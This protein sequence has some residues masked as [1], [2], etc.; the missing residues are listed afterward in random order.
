MTIANF[1]FRTFPI[2]VCRQLPFLWR[3][4]PIFCSG[5]LLILLFCPYPFF[6][7][8]FYYLNFEAIFV[9]ADCCFFLYRL[10]AK[11]L[12]RPPPSSCLPSSPAHQQAGF[13]SLTTGRMVRN[14]WIRKIFSILSL[15][16]V[17]V[18]IWKQVLSTTEWGETLLH[19]V[20]LH[21]HH[22][23]PLLTMDPRA[24]LVPSTPL[25]RPTPRW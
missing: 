4:F 24:G 17:K 25:S 22:T 5:N 10:F 18:K 23:I 11:C 3:L 6:V 15:I 13:S 21:L 20:P 19:M 7:Q 12:C 2:F 9:H 14:Y 8:A 16:W 1:L